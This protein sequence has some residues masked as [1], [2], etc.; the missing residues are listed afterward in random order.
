MDVGDKIRT[1]R[2]NARMTQGELAEKLH[3]TPQAVSNWERGERLPGHD[4]IPALSETLGVSY[5]ELFDE[6]KILEFYTAEEKTRL[7]RK[8][9]DTAPLANRLCAIL[10]CWE[11]EDRRIHK[12]EKEERRRRGVKTVSN[13][14]FRKLKTFYDLDPLGL[15]AG[16]T[17]KRKGI[18]SDFIKENGTSTMRYVLMILFLGEDLE[19]NA[20]ELPE[21]SDPG[22]MDSVCDLLLTDQ[23]DYHSLANPY[24]EIL[25][26][27]PELIAEW[28][29]GG[30]KVM[31]QAV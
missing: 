18:L 3:V 2:Q 22:Y 15:R 27:R 23:D 10:D 20:W 24:Y 6:E 5:K 29:R 14:G 8:C 17:Q 12:L 30:L 28:I 13:N 7:L 31:I 1:C 16:I 4:I 21:V 11:Q 25:E 19:H 26:K 9:V